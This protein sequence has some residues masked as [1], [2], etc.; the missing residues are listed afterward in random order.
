MWVFPVDGSSKTFSQI[1]I[2]V[3]SWATTWIPVV[4]EGQRVEKL[5]SIRSRGV[6]VFPKLSLLSG[7][8]WLRMFNKKTRWKYSQPAAVI[9][10][11][12][13]MLR[14]WRSRLAL[15]EKRCQQASLRLNRPRFVSE[16]D[17][18]LQRNHLLS[19]STSSF[20]SFCVLLQ[21]MIIAFA[22]IL[23]VVILYIPHWIVPLQYIVLVSDINRTG[24][25]RPLY[26]TD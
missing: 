3:S 17:T 21:T 11:N 24:P 20:S 19:F 25:Q 8:P 10:Y 6:V 2:L 16:I 12:I 14:R 4:G 22:Q 1:M 15:E 9:R 13:F 7:F 18:S 23:L 26:S 5:A